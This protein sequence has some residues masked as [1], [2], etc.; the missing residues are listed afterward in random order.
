MSWINRLQERWKLKNAFQVVLIL[1]AFACTGFTV[2]FLRE[3]IVGYFTAEG[4]QNVW[5][6]IIYY[7]LIF[8]VYNIILLIYG[9]L[10]G[11]FRFFW[12]FEKKTFRRITGRKEDV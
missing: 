11:Q 7:I 12:E 6:S 8:P 9:F 2:L 5:F 1:I 3:P 10:L 4:E